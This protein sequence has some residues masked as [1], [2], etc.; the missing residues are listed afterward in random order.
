[1]LE[2]A[3][4]SLAQLA[5]IHSGAFPSWL[6]LYH[7]GFYGCCV[8]GS[9]CLSRL[10]VSVM[11]AKSRAS[12]ISLVEGGGCIPTAFLFSAWKE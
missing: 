6:V 10:R 5:W 11:M 9:D 1:M 2:R 12:I 3:G 7:W 8:G 4:A